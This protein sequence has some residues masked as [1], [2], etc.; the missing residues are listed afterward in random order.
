MFEFSIVITI[1]IE[2]IIV[3]YQKSSDGIPRLE[4]MAPYEL[5]RSL[6]R[7]SMMLDKVPTSWEVQNIL[8][9]WNKLIAYYAMY[10]FPK[11]Y[12]LAREISWSRYLFW[13]VSQSSGYFVSL[14]E[15]VIGDAALP[16]AS[17]FCND[18][19]ISWTYEIFTSAS[20]AS[21]FREWSTTSTLSE[22]P[23]S[24]GSSLWISIRG[25]FYNPCLKY[26]N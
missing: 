22:I 8:M 26:M 5:A 21:A 11:M 9:N 3:I 18:E 25:V 2:L 17:G 1:T 15:S 7:K 24:V 10:Q 20:P 12:N 16:K 19:V 4:K 6:T 23:L 13:S 14:S